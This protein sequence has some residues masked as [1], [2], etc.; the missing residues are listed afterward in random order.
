[1]T[2]RTR[3]LLTLVLVSAAFC[4]ALLLIRRDQ[5]EFFQKVVE[6]REREW[7]QAVERFLQR[8]ERPPAAMVGD[9]ATELDLV[10]A[11]EANDPAL[12]AA[13]LDD[14]TLKSR[15][16]H[17]VWL[18]RADGTLLHAHSLPTA[19]QQLD[20]QPLPGVDLRALLARDPQ[21]HFYF[22]FPGSSGGA[23][24]RFVEVRGT[25]VVGKVDN[26]DGSPRALG[27]LFA[28][29]LLDRQEVTDLPLLHLD[30]QVELVAATA[31]VPG[32]TE[33]TLSF[34]APLRDWQ[35]REIGRFVVWN[36]SRELAAV[37]SRGERHLA[38][39]VAAVLLLFAVIFLA[40]SRAILRPLAVI[41]RSLDERVD[42]PL[43]PLLG[44]RSEI[45]DLARLVRDHLQQSS[46]LVQEMNRRINTQTAL[47]ESDEMLRHSQKLEAVGRL[48]GG[49]AHDFNNLLTAIIGYAS[50]LRRRCAH[51][52]AALQEAQ[53]IHQAGEQAA[54]LTRQLLAFSRKQLLQPKVVDLDQIVR[55]LERLLQRII[56]ERIEV[57]T[58][59][60]SVASCVRADPG[61]IEQVIVNLGVNARDAMPHGGRL[62]IRT[63]DS[64]LDGAAAELSLPPGRYVVLEVS[65][66]GEGMDA[67][68]RA[69]I[70]EPFFTTKAPGK[71]TGLGLSTVYGIVRQSHGT[72][73]VESERGHGTTFRIYLPWQ[74]GAPEVVE[75][76][77]PALE[78][79][80]VP[81]SVLVVEDEEIVRDLV[82]EVLRGEGYRVAGADRGSE[83]LRLVR[84]DFRDVDLLISDLV[85]PEMNG[86]EVARRV[87]ELAPLARV[88]FVSGYSESDIADQGL[89]ELKFEVLQKPFTPEVLVRKVR[90]ILD[91][92]S[93]SS[94]SGGGG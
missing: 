79:A 40:L 42:A 82:V 58:D 5:S 27:T 94:S 41:A 10:A 43:L 75:V 60:C 18:Y 77:V 61:Q 66:V 44:Q 59:L 25:P 6:T 69:Q 22:E 62:T 39:T 65:D 35:G 90:E 48:A 23:Q 73:T 53:L 81:A 24:R 89:G 84:E 70:F 1:M 17:A 47:R 52:P 28:G 33:H 2:V 72:V 78:P 19:A 55:Q 13:A 57:I 63:T 85:M 16:L 4:G 29:C 68:T 49:V 50:L 8:Q 30:D 31:P 34:A 45:G 56:G 87:R 9:L 93:S 64:V 14:K 11:L 51:D 38:A 26:A 67:E 88:L 74:D 7:R 20:R 37:E 92:S 76:A 91:S 80:R 36:N 71:G 46:A 15:A 54:G 21:P 3:I 83:A 12:A 32:E 86:S